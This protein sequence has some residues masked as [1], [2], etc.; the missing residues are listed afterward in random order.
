[1]LQLND[2][3]KSKLIL[4]SGDKTTLD[5]LKKLFLSEFLQRKISSG[6]H[7]LAA[8]KLAV[9]LLEDGFRKLENFKEKEKEKIEHENVI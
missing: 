4:L 7:E 2:T 8:A 5:G 3:E 6:V 1:M 9:E